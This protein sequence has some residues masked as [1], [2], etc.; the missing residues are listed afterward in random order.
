MARSRYSNTRIIDGHHYATWRNPVAERMDGDI[1]EGVKTFD[2]TFS[3]GDR[4]DILAAKYLGDDRYY[5]IIALVNNIIWPLGIE[6][7]TTLRIPKDV[8]QVLEKLQ[9]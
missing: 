7:G 3:I 2:Y 4:L 8:T 5:W 1:L 6:P 9:R